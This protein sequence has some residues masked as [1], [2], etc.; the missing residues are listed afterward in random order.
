LYN[1]FE[2]A[3]DTGFYT[4]T[5]A[6]FRIGGNADKPVLKGKVIDE[7][8]RPE[9]WN[10]ESLRKAEIVYNAI[11]KSQG[12]P[13][14]NLTHVIEKEVQKPKAIEN[15]IETVIEPITKSVP[16]I[17]TPEFDSIS[18]AKEEGYEFPGKKRYSSFEDA[19][20]DA[21]SRGDNFEVVKIGEKFRVGKYTEE[22]PRGEY[23]PEVVETGEARRVFELAK[24]EEARKAA[25]GTSEVD[26][27][28]SD[29][30]T[31]EDWKVLEEITQG[32]NLDEI[33]LGEEVVAE[34]RAVKESLP[35]EV[36]KGRTVDSASA[37]QKFLEWRDS[38]V[39][40]RNVATH[41]SVHEF[42]EFDSNFNKTG[43]G[44][45]AFGKGHYFTSSKNVKKHYQN[46][47][48]NI[49]IK[50]QFLEELA[51]DASFEEAMELIETKNNPKQITFMK[52]LEKNDWLGFD[53]P[54]QAISAAF[55]DL[56][57]FEVTKELKDAIENYTNVY[58]VKLKPKENEYILWDKPMAEQY[59]KIKA[60]MEEESFS[61]TSIGKDFYRMLK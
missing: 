12:L 2:E 55:K 53:Y 16:E 28:Y 42:T 61:N 38:Y 19:Q 23:V 25:E 54:A 29:G 37:A 43:E 34:V 33:R 40:K 39:T 5:Y 45:N 59:P 46:S 11:S 7:D 1:Y 49:D 27:L 58:T 32:V 48:P 17:I 3:N 22:A 31:A 15:V 44:R 60:V 30:V 6:K 13:T 47:L 50:R 9:A 4:R 14:I 51:E 21:T 41:V 52:E 56:E 18:I 26:E 35:P 36:P 20:S 24:E 8:G 57:G 10:S